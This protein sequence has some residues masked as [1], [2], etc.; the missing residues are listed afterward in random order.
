MNRPPAD[1]LP[2]SPDPLAVALSRLE[3]APHGLDRE[4]LL[5]AAGRAACQGAVTFWR[6]VA[7]LATAVAALL[8]TLYLTR[9]TR[10]E[11]IDR[12]VIVTPSDEAVSPP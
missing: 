8:A 9:P 6:T 1:P 2:P 12:P 4:V 3:P 10:I 5:F 7:A 11:Y